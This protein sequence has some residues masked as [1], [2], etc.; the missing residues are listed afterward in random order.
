MMR[1]GRLLCALILLAAGHRNAVLVGAFAPPRPL[2]PSR[3]AA[4]VPA[5]P[6]TTTTTATVR[7]RGAAS[8]PYPSSA[9]GTPGSVSGNYGELLP[10]IAEIDRSNGELFAR[11]EGLRD[12]PYFRY[13][14]V[15]ILAS[16]EYMP[17]E[18]FECYT[19]SCEIY[20][21]DEEQVSV[22]VH[23]VRAVFAAAVVFASGEKR[24]ALL[25]SFSVLLTP[26]VLLPLMVDAR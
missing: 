9:G 25:M 20:P 24:C 13:Y 19:E 14:S 15:D 16:C 23:D 6:T 18:L 17:Q 12:R 2:I 22:C 5:A 1:A 7:L 11:L 10:G 26:C 21:E 8:S 3:G 4:R